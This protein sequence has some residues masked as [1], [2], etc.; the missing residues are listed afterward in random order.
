[1]KDIV[2]DR[3]TVTFGEN[4]V[5]SDFSLIIPAGRTSC[6][7]GQSGCG[8]TTL[9]NVLLG[10]IPP[11]KG[12]VRGIP[13]NVA[14]VFQEN[15]L[16]DNFSALANLRAVSKTADEE[17]L[18]EE[19]LALDIDPTDRKP[20]RELSGGQQR[21]VAIARALCTDADFTVLD[22]PF[23]GLDEA[24]AQKVMD[25]VKTRTKD[26][27]VLLITHAPEQASFFGGNTVRMQ[28]KDKQ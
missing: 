17:K 4:T 9:G 8:K 19:L 16:C 23:K 15:R 22:E 27:T 21:R 24:T 12:S 13:E 25:R 3:I 28:S 26:K 18:K 20:V 10:L 6:I 1:M 5:L 2:V 7:M 14:A 11:D